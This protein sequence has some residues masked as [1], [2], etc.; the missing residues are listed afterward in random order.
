M[1]YIVGKAAEG[2]IPLDITEKQVFMQILS[3]KWQKVVFA[4]SPGRNK[5]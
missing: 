1:I 4:P 3:S 5:G 2:R